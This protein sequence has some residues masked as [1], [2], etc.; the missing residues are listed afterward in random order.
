MILSFS[1]LHYFL[2]NFFNHFFSEFY[3]MNKEVL[4]VKHNIKLFFLEEK[5]H[6]IVIQTC[7]Q[8]RKRT[9]VT[10]H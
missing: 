4:V 9:H 2:I 5:T 3:L 10:E 1:D 7:R 6:H 8:I